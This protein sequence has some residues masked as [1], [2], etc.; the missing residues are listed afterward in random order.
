MSDGLTEYRVRESLKA[1]RGIQVSHEQL[2][3]WRDWGLLEQDPDGRWSPETIERA[4]RIHELG[5]TIDSYARRVILLNGEGFPVPPRQLQA[6]MAE[7]APKIHPHLRKMKRVERALRELSSVS[8]PTSLKRSARLPRGWK[9]PPAAEWGALLLET[10]LAHFEN[11]VG[12]Q[13]YFAGVL[14]TLVPGPAED[15]LNQIPHEELLILLTVRQFAAL[16]ETRRSAIQERADAA[17]RTS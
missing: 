6:A 14:R 9:P 5:R 7:V 13:Y 3:A 8:T 17:S 4:A 2:F 16:G 10:D 12:L 11:T 15:S 1:A